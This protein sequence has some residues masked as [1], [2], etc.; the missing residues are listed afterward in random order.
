MVLYTVRSFHLYW[1]N[2]MLIGQ[3]PSRKYRWGEQTRA[4]LGRGKAGTGQTQR[5]HNKNA[6][7]QKDTES[8][9]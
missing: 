2:K 5:K 8:D 6:L 3:Y 9:V 4:F 1:V 7:M